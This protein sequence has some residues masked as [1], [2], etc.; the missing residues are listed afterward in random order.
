MHQ[1]ELRIEGKVS[2]GLLFRHAD[3]SEYGQI[4]AVAVHAIDAHNEAFL[5]LRR[6]GFR[7][8]EIRHA[9][10]HV[11]QQVDLDTTLRRALELLTESVFAR[12][13]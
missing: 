1:G 13:S 9:L 6:L 5:A 8:T 2:T 10:A 11:G 12:A 4:A 3:G 7:E